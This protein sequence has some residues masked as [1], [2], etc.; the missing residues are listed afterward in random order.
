MQKTI[1]WDVGSGNIYLDYTG[2]GNGTIVVTSDDNDVDQQRSKTLTITAGSLTKT[3][4]VVQ[5]ASP[6]FKTSNSKFIILSNG[7]TFNVTEQQMYNSTHT[8]EEFETILDSIPSKLNYI[9]DLEGQLSQLGFGY[10][11]CSTASNNAAK[12]VTIS[13]FILLKGGII[14][15]YFTNVIST[16]GT[17]LNISSTGAKDIYYHGTALPANLIKARTVVMLQYDGT[18]YN[19][20][21]YEPIVRYF[22]DYVDLGLPSGLLWAKKNL[23]LRQ[24]SGF[25]VSE[26]QYECAFFSWGN[27]DPHYPTSDTTLDYVFKDSNYNTTTGKNASYSAGIAGGAYDASTQLIGKPWH[28]PSQADCNELLS[29]CIYIDANGDEIPSSTNDKRIT[30]NGITGLRLKSTV[31]GNTLFLPACGYGYTTN[32]LSSDAWVDKG[33]VTAF[34]TSSGKSSTDAYVFSGE[35]SA[36]S[37]TDVRRYRGYPIRP[38]Q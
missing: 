15:V 33:A 11:T 24:P 23:D 6:N 21:K 37:V 10:T 7:D 34:W 8:D 35:S 31:N 12:V 14:G 20:I 18:R 27:V 17:T 38:V 28:I 1:A 25:C 9:A 13:N 30:L 32:A 5:G 19:V 22:G 29:Y 4:T 16:T 2:V 26:Y 36:V 3:V